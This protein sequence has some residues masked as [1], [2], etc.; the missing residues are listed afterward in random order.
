MKN[1]AEHPE[2]YAHK[3]EIKTAKNLKVLEVGVTTDGY[4]MKC[5]DRI[6]EEVFVAVFRPTVR[7]PLG[8]M[9]CSNIGCLTKPVCVHA[10]RLIMEINE[11]NWLK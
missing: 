1:V 9:R 3:E 4:Y 2:Y 11:R 10:V 7:S 5:A 6:G 8:A